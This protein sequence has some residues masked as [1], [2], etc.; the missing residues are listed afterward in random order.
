MRSAEALSLIATIA[1]DLPCG[2][3]VASAPDGRF[4]YSNRAFDEIMGMGPVND[5][6]VGEY[7]VPYGIYGRDGALYPEHRLPFVRALEER[8]TVVVDDIV[9]HRRDG[10]R[11][12]VRAFGKPMVDEEGAIRHVAIAFFD[13]TR[14]V[15]AQQ[16]HSRSEDRLRQIVAHAPVVLAAC[17]RAGIVTLVEGRGLDRI[18]VQ[19]DFVGKSI[20]DLYPEVPAIAEGVRRAL[21]GEA[22][23]HLTNLGPVAY[24]THL[25]PMR[26]ATGE[27]VGTISVSIDITD[28]Q[29]MQG[30]LARAERLAS[31]G[32][33]AAG[34]AHEVNNPLSFVL[35]NLELAE[36]DAAAMRGTAGAGVSEMLKTF[37]QRLRDS[38]MG[39]E[40]VRTIV[41]DLRVF[42]RVDEQPLH[43]VD[44]CAAIEASLTMAQ[45]EIRHRARL[46]RDFA[47]VAK[48]MA[49]EGRL[50]QV[51]VNLLIN[52]AHAIPAG[53]AEKHEIRVVTRPGAGVVTV[54]VHDTGAGI[55]PDV[56]PRIFD[57]FFTTKGVGAG[58]GLG[59]SVCHAI[60]TA[61]GGRIELTSTLGQRTTVRVVLPEVSETGAEGTEAQPDAPRAGRRGSVLV[62]DDEPL[63]VRV[64]A[65]I[66]TPEHDVT[67]ETGA[68][69]A[70]ARLRAGERF[71]AI[72]CDLMMPQIT[73]MD[74]YETLCEIAPAQAQVMLFLTGGAFTAR[75]SSF[76]ERVSDAALEKPIDS[77]MLRD[78]VRRFVG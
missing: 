75:A 20:F 32:M 11:V 67:C 49:D 40:R 70:L 36:Q 50:S 42:S 59:L 23:S 21:A 26:D 68:E 9:I 39:A 38:R 25:A 61:L 4:V 78:K 3:W 15:E 52:A 46:V 69:A 13:I 77:K 37:E 53:E 14:E 5:V 72:V 60:V 34:V 58:T 63:I 7:A 27:V 65:A 57:P 41:R 43:P 76:L 28:R 19:A 73:G 22:N 18:G 30:Q 66:L 16:A 31:L 17:D 55:A 10:R 54:E 74:L 64:V 1:D 8:T 62:I 48:V 24:E 35:G 2:V 33:L 51:F 56:L 44:V 29:H 6:G 45:N 47:P 71:D 12:Y